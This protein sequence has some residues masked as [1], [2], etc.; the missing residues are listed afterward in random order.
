MNFTFFIR[1]CIRDTLNNIKYNRT[2]FPIKPEDDEMHL[3]KTIDW[4]VLAC[5]HGKG[6]VS[7]HYSLLHGK[8]L[9][10][11]PETTG[12]IIP[13]LFDSS[14]FANNEY[15]FDL[16][17]KLTDW[18]GQVQ[19][20]NGACMQGSY[21]ERIGKTKPIV[22]NT[23]QNIFGFIRAYQETGDEKYLSFA[24]KAGDFLVMSTDQEGI[25]DKHLLRN[26]KHTINSRTSWALLELHR[27]LKNKDYFRVALKNL[28]WVMMQQF[29]N[30]WFLH[31]TSRNGIL[32]N[33]HF[34]AYTCRGL[35]ESYRIIGN[36][37]Y[38]KTTTKT[39]SR[40][41]EIFDER[42]MLYAFWDEQWQ[43]RGKYLRRGKGRFVCLTGNI[44]I[45]IVWMK[46]YRETGEN[47]YLNAAFKMLDHIKAL[48]NIETNKA[49]VNGGIKGS[50]PVYG[51]YSTLKYPNWAAKFFVDALLLKIKIK[52]SLQTPE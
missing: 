41:L 39:A 51:S 23:G 8:W 19:L 1:E 27:L 26:L 44:Q 22:F 45:S 40:M 6:G 30:G 24:Q 16:A 37:S 21:N 20:E 5:R 38:L 32:P 34:L 43:N 12:Y 48:Q 25:W 28:E 42:K 7:S 18:L 10:P 9:D 29:E 14:Y 35:L 47:R 4:L 3:K 49:G 46:L 13:T 33:T 15:Y 36:E 2:R 17:V 52:N 11:F 31:G 50:F